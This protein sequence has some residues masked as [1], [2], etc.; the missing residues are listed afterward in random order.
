[1]R[2][3]QRLREGAVRFVT[4]DAVLVEFL[5]YFSAWGQAAR[6]AAVEYTRD[7]RIEPVIDVIAYSRE[8]FD[9]ALDF[10]LRR[11]DKD[12]SMT[13][14]ISMVICRDAQIADVLTAD[15]DFEQEGFTILL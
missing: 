15:H 13:D 11:P 3:V 6:T 9:A 7:L 2:A 4:S 14:C 8:L 12:Y 10:Y 1:M 5:T